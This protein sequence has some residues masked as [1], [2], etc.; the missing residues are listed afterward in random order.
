MLKR[1]EVQPEG[2]RRPG[3]RHPRERSSPAPWLLLF[4]AAFAAR[5]LLLL[6]EAS[7]TRS[8]SA[9][10]DL[11]IIASNLAR[12]GGFSL[13]LGAAALP[14]ASVA[15][16]LPWL[17]SLV[18]RLGI[19][20]PLVTLLVPCLIGALI[21]LLTS[22]LASIVLGAASARVA[23]W[24]AALGPILLTFSTRLVPDTMMT[25]AMLSAL[26]LTA[27]W[28]RTPEPG[29]ALGAGIAWGM[30]ALASDSA[31]LLPVLVLAWA[32]IPL[33]LTV[34]HR[35]RLR[36]A[37]LLMLGCVIVI[38]PWTI[39]N[40]IALRA[41]VLVTTGAGSALLD[42]NNETVWSDPARRGGGIRARALDP[43]AARGR[44]LSEPARDREAARAAADFAG[45][46]ASEA[47]R[48][49]V[50]KL[51]RLW[52]LSGR[53]ANLV[54]PEGQGP[55]TLLDRMPWLLAAWSIV[56]LPLA[57]F[58]A[59]RVLSGPKRWFQSLPLL[60]TLYFTACAI[61]FYGCVR[62]RVPIEPM[63]ALFAAAGFD[64]ARRF[65][66]RRASGLKVIEGGR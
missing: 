8:A 11:E 26:A 6:F 35:D 29:R 5:A 4:A 45:G 49:I 54:D 32:W 34:A 63:V 43:G 15:P 46:H 21:P 31:L 28:I 22:A 13:G 66:R 2:P 40:A 50:A 47:P 37:A 55:A 20:R 23:G 44:D 58:G 17:L 19:H 3:R 12:G 65:T 64:E 30:T 62:Q 53:D 56:I 60:V 10:S 14:T 61:V 7:V 48:V 42:G 16:V 41:P 51:G 39:R 33:G 57:L 27:S 9:P 38:A 52:T 25:A 24:I 1:A 36:Q 18:L 59:V